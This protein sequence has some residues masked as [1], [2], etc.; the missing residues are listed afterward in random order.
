M[1]IENRR[2]SVRSAAMTYGLP[3]RVV[4][5]AIKSGELPAVK[6]VTETGQER[7]YISKTD[8]ETWISSLS[9][10]DSASSVGGV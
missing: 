10:A 4:A 5:R 7:A 3:T 9:T 2:M 6:T 8:V 1:S